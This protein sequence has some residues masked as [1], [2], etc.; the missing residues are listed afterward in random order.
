M[1]SNYFDIRELVS[2]QVH[3]KYGEM[4]WDFFDPRLIQTI[5]F[6]KEYFG[7]TVTINNWLWNGDFS[8][9]GLR[10]NMDN[11]VY[12]K[13]LQDK[14]YCSAHTRGM[15]VDFDVKNLTA[16]EARHELIKNENKLPHPIRLEKGV[17]WVHLDV[18]DK[19]IKTYLFN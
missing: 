4:A 13:T 10:C 6:L 5:D 1:K 8:Q 3:Q 14:I 11:I 12:N 7:W 19:G 16:E 18:V 17:S 2:K 15:A 9:R